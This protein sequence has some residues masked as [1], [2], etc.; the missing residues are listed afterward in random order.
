MNRLQKTILACAWVVTYL[1]FVAAI[2]TSHDT[3]T[4]SRLG[5]T[6]GL[7]AFYAYV[8]SFTWQVWP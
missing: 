2:W 8:V 4:S 3:P 1:L 5:M 6:G 7:S